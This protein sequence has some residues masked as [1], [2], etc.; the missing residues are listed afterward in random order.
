M[1]ILA[2]VVVSF[3][4]GWLIRD[5]MLF[6]AKPKEEPEHESS[7]ECEARYYETYEVTPSDR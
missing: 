4:L 3:S 2:V 7:S 1:Y 6:L 5:L